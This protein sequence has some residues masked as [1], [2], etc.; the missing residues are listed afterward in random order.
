[1]A[2]RSIAPF[3][4]LSLISSQIVTV[5]KSKSSKLLGLF[6]VRRTIV[7]RQALAE[8]IKGLIK[9]YREATKE[10]KTEYLDQAQVI[11]GK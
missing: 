4:R 3:M 8:Y 6:P 5:V 7:S 11:T 9:L 2:V 10:K 1:M